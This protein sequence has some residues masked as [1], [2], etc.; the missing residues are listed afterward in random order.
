[1]Q[2]RAAPF[3][4][5]FKPFRFK[6]ALAVAELASEPTSPPSLGMGTRR[7]TADHCGHGEDDGGAGKVVGDHF[8]AET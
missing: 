8:S 7:L 2:T 3:E 1:M 4:D 5:W 6:D